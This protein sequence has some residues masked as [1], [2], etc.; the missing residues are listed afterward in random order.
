MWCAL[1]DQHHAKNTK[2]LHASL[3]SSLILYFAAKLSVMENV[4]GMISFVFLIYACSSCTVNRAISFDGIDDYVEVGNIYDQTQYPVTMCGWILLD[5]EAKGQNPLFQSQSNDNLYNGFWLVVNPTHLFSGYGDGRGENHHQ[6]RRDKSSPHTDVAGKWIHVAAVAKN[7][8]DIDVFLNGELLPGDYYG[9][10]EFPMSSKFPD[11][12]ARFGFWRSNGSNYYFKG[13]MD[14][15]K[16]WNRALTP[17]EIRNEH[18]GVAANDQSLIG[19]WTFDEKE[20][21]KV[22]DNSPNQHHGELKGGAQRIKLDKNYKSQTKKLQTEE[23]SKE[24]G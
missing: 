19:Y 5:K 18:N 4:G 11:A 9:S 2:I 10:S 14:N 21:S 16:I 23:T 13:M 15:F 22:K 20:G 12:T 8:H 1:A 6:Y 3:S 24:P 17:D 7:E